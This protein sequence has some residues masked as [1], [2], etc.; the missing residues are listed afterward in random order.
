MLHKRVFAR[1]DRTRL[2]GH[3]DLNLFIVVHNLL[4]YTASVYVY[5]FTRADR[6]PIVH[7]LYGPSK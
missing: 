2:S 6:V 5:V 4:P 7:P 3:L 1:G